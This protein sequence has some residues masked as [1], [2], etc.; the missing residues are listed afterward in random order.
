MMVV[1]GDRATEADTDSVTSEMGNL[2][3]KQRQYLAIR[4]LTSTDAEAAREA[5]VAPATVARWKGE[6]EF[7]VAYDAV[8]TDAVTTAIG[9]L[10]QTTALAA[11]RITEA[12]NAEREDGSPDWQTRLKASELVLKGSGTWTE[13]LHVRADLQPSYQREEVHLTPEEK[14]AIRRALVGAADL[15][16][17][18]ITPGLREGEKDKAD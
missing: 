15:D 6:P 1:A 3:S 16:A 10:R 7:L 5:N 11:L 9:H 8:F 4:V 2:T 14:Q 17:E 12:L 18:A 13:R